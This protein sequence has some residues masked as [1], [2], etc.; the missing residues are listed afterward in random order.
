MAGFYDIRNGRD[1]FFGH[2]FDNFVE[3]ILDFEVAVSERDEKIS[4]L[5]G[6]ISALESQIDSME[7]DR[8]DR[9]E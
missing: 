1:R 6:D 4:E 8:D 3:A 5:L 7:H 2:S 9:G